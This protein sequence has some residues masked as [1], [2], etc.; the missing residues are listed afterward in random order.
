MPLVFYGSKTEGHRKSAALSTRPTTL[1]GSD[2]RKGQSQE[3]TETLPWLNR[4]SLGGKTEMDLRAE[5]SG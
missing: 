3:V 1:L 2:A 5:S 4:V